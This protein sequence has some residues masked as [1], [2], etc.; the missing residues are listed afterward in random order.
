MREGEKFKHW[1]IIASFSKDIEGLELEKCTRPMKV[2]NVR[3][4]SS[5]DDMTLGQMVQMSDCK[6]G[7]ELF[8]RVCKVLLG[9]EAKK[10]DDCFAVEVVRFVGWVLGKVKTIN[11]LFDKAKSQPSDEE[12]RAGV[13]QLNFGIFGLIDWYAIR[14]GITDHEEVTKVPWGRVYKCLDMDKRTNDYRKKLQKVYEDE[15]RK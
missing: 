1:I 2:G 7:A 13:N 8:Y 11:E 10:V 14:M 6:T 4:P 3:T 15:H 9:M 12:I 5:L